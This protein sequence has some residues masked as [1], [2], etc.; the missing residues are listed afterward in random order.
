MVEMEIVEKKGTSSDGWM[1]GIRLVDVR[2][3][4]LY[5]LARKITTCIIPHRSM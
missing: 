2:Y 4:L 3:Q 1:S 5:L